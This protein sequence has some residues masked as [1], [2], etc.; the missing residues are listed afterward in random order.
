MKKFLMLLSLAG[1]CFLSCNKFDD[2][3]IWAELNS[4]KS[5]I[6]EL[7][8]LCSKINN[9]VIAMQT[10]INSLNNH[11]TIT[12][13]APIMD[14]GVEKGYTITF[15]NGS[16]IT[17]YHGNNGKDGT[18]GKDGVDGT[19][20]KDGVDG[21]DGITPSLS[22]LKDT[23]GVYYWT[24]NGEWLLDGKGNKLRVSGEDGKNGVDGTDGTDGVNG[25]N[26]KDGKDGVTPQLKIENGYWHISYDNGTSWTQLDAATGSDGDTL[27]KD[28][29]QDE[30]GVY[31]TLADGSVITIPKDAEFSLKLSDSQVY[32]Y[33]GTS[34]IV[35]FEVKGA[36]ENTRIE[37]LGQGGLIATTT[38]QDTG[39]GQITISAE[40]TFN[41][42]K[43]I[44][45]AYDGKD[46]TIMASINVVK[47]Y[48]SLLSSPSVNLDSE[49]GTFSIEVSTNMEYDIVLSEEDKKWLSVKNV[50]TGDAQRINFAYT[51]NIGPDRTADISFVTKDGMVISSMSITQEILT[52]DLSASGTANCYLVSRAGKYIFKT[53]K[54]NST[55]SVGSIA[56][57][58]VLWETYGSDIAPSVGDLVSDVSYANGTVAFVSSDK[59]GN[60]LI[61]AEDANGVILWSWHIWLTDIP[62]DQVYINDAGTMMDRNLGAISTTPG[63]I[64]ALGLLYQWG[65]KDPFLGQSTIKGTN[66]AASTRPVHLWTSVDSDEAYGTIEYSIANPTTFIKDDSYWL[67]KSDNTLWTNE[68]TIYDPCP[69]GYHVPNRNMWTTAFK[70]SSWFDYTYDDI[71]NGCNFIKAKNSSK[72]LT[73]DAS[74]WY[75]FAGYLSSS[76]ASISGG[77]LLYWVCSYYPLMKGNGSGGLD[78]ACGGIYGG[79]YSTARGGSVRCQKE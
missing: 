17:I 43:I 30:N 22:V 44:V 29:R 21:K 15:S 56:S 38:M 57:V 51:E 60:A 24:L 12:A 64:G 19:N 8:Q 26:G 23:D 27:F 47:Y 14:N 36:D 58:S 25:S 31:F 66:K 55:K 72:Y 6:E 3:A 76:N 62:E 61:A 79:A 54:G 28:V 59:K 69:I 34:V 75:P 2:S 7:K 63:D 35:E 71:N 53:V 5:E 13:T 41:E 33:L 11:Y 68:K 9:D 40:E 4:Q 48:F 32:L 52:T 78:P 73:N 46:R 74:C 65:R 45:L 49:A 42:N 10:I 16:T 67:H 39:K 77:D 18:N 1:F 37:A 70:T 20:G 50:E